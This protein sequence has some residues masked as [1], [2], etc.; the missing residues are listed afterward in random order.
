MA[1][2]ITLE[3]GSTLE[4]D[5]SQ[6]A[7]PMN[8]HYKLDL[9]GIDFTVA[10]KARR[11]CTIQSNAAGGNGY[12]DCPD[13]PTSLHTVSITQCDFKR[14][15][16]PAVAALEVYGGN[17]DFTLTYCTFDACSYLLRRHNPKTN[18]TIRVE[19]NTWVNTI[20]TKCVGSLSASTMMGTGARTLKWNTFDLPCNLDIMRD[21][22][23]EGNFFADEPPSLLPN[24]AYASFTSNCIVWTAAADGLVTSGNATDC[25]FI[26][27]TGTNNPQFID[28]SSLDPVDVTID[29]CLFATDYYGAADGECIRGLLI[30]AGKEIH[31][32]NCIAL[33]TASYQGIG[34]VVYAEGNVN[35]TL[36]CTHNTAFAAGFQVG[37]TYAGHAGMLV[38]FKDNL[39][40]YPSAGAGQYF[41]SDQSG[42][43]TDLAAASSITHNCGVNLSTGTNGVGYD[44]FV[45]S[46][47]TPGTSDLAVDPQFAEPTRSIAT[48]DTADTGLNNAVA[49]A[50]ATG[51][52]YVAGD[53]VSSATPGV[54]GGE[55]VNYRCINPH[56]SL[57]ADATN[58]EPYA[59]GVTGWRT[60]WELATLYRLRNDATII[61]FLVTWLKH[62]F[63][64][65]NPAIKNKGHDGVTT[66]AVEGIW[67]I[68]HLLGSVSLNAT[69]RLYVGEDN[70]VTWTG[71]TNIAAAGYVLDATVTMSVLDADKLVF[72]SISNINLPYVVGSDGDY[73]GIISADD[74]A[75]LVDHDTYF[76]AIDAV[77]P[78]GVEGYRL[79]EQR[80]E[81][82]R[83]EAGANL[84]GEISVNAN[85][86]LFIGEDN[87]VKWT[88]M[89]APDGS[90]VN[91]AIVKLSVLDTNENVYQSITGLPMTY[92]AGSNGNY[93]G[94]I[95]AAS[96]AALVYRTAYLVEV[97]AA[98]PSGRAGHRRLRLRARYH[99][100]RLEVIT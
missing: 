48:F 25:V 16:L 90:Y 4:F 19:H 70:F 36:H 93:H 83:T 46:T 43:I 65:T 79:I 62:G 28:V 37:N 5:S 14:V 91:N 94:V 49:T 81:Y 39:T 88:G 35:T 97:T 42:T 34:K 78:L 99:D 2:K 77:T 26:D 74:A 29:G 51:Q 64:P 98:D 58:G 9:S 1:M 54:W 82:H 80:A 24:N 56:A 50:W 41:V 63:M 73:R 47:G 22:T 71:M 86:L 59:A 85:D 44:G 23:I 3:A 66:G 61:P 75:S 33:P 13:E 18:T 57:T 100:D 60:N 8:Q 17:E 95:D 92:I 32:K 7:D 30:P 55:T 15:G 68:G 52:N 96:A 21:Y 72:D 89:A 84:A 40:V 10:G 31:V 45:F 38:E 11:R 12:V 69:G 27:A 20:G 67:T 53:I 6:A 76:I 87:Y